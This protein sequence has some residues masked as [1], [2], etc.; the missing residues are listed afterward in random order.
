MFFELYSLKDNITL[1]SE[2]EDKLMTLKKL[3]P[4]QPHESEDLD[5]EIAEAVL[6]QRALYEKLLAFA[7]PPIGS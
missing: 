5:L 3:C 1:V 4:W 6:R 2:K 7:R